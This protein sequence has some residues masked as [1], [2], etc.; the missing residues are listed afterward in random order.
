MLSSYWC[1]I[2]CNSRMTQAR[3]YSDEA[4]IQH[5]QPCWQEFNQ[6]TW[7]DSSSS[8]CLTCYGSSLTS[9][10]LTL[11]C[12]CNIDELQVALKLKLGEGVVA[13]AC[14]LH[15]LCVTNPSMYLV[16][17][18]TFKGCAQLYLDNPWLDSLSN[19]F[20]TCTSWLTLC[21]RYLMMGTKIP[22]VIGLGLQW[23]NR[24]ILHDWLINWSSSIEWSK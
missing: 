19:G 12:M 9:L 7:M 20:L 6:S 2:L 21:K 3:G 15:A 18:W 4:Y 13:H 23:Q 5:S 10:S 16:D 11:F 14:S 8:T 1:A 17:C 24:S 22:C